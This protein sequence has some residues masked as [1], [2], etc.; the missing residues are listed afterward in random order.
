MVFAFA[1]HHIDSDA[2]NYAA[3]PKTDNI[4]V[5]RHREAVVVHNLQCFAQ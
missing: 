3:D 4:R 5:V 1:F 2:G